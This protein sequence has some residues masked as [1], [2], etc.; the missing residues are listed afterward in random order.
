ML[1]QFA[2]TLIGAKL[3]PVQRYPIYNENRPLSKL[4]RL[5]SS[6]YLIT[7]IAADIC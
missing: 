2:I 7:K 1:N 6:F 4:F 3:H 5:S